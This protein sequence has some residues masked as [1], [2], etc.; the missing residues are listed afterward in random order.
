MMGPWCETSKD[1]FIRKQIPKNSHCMILTPSAMYP[2]FSRYE[3]CEFT[4]ITRESENTYTVD[5]ECKIAG[6]GDVAMGTKI[7]RINGNQ[8]TMHEYS[9][10]RP[11]AE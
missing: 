5:M 10:Q 11:A 8:L 2:S 4:G 3:S 7:F 9:T 6:G 1:I